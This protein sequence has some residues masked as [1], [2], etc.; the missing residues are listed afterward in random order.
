MKDLPILSKEDKDQMILK[1]KIYLLYLKLTDEKDI[2]NCP[3]I[4]KKYI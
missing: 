4:T 2:I 3:S 1:K